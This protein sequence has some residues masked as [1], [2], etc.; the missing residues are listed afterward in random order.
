M[1]SN[2]IV[3][4]LDTLCVTKRSQ[5]TIRIFD[6]ARCSR[7][8]TGKLPEDF[9]PDSNTNQRSMRKPGLVQWDACHQQIGNTTKP[10]AVIR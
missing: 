4:N 3:D 8:T 1:H 10:K 7:S 2:S 9:D 6:H 5:L